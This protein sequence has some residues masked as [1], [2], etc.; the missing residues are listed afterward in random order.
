MMATEQEHPARPT[1][2]SRVHENHES[3]IRAAIADLRC[4]THFKHWPPAAL[5]GWRKQHGKPK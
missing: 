2:G 4:A 1:P 5:A 3:L